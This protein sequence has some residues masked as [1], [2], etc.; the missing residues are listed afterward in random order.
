MAL[1]RRVSAG[2]LAF[3]LCAL[4]VVIV[5]NGRFWEVPPLP[6]VCLSRCVEGSRMSHPLP[7]CAPCRDTELPGRSL[8]RRY[9]RACRRSPRFGLRAS[10]CLAP[11]SASAGSRRGGRLSATISAEWALWWLRC[12]AQPLFAN[13][14]LRVQHPLFWGRRWLLPWLSGLRWADDRRRA[15]LPDGAAD[16]DAADDATHDADH[17]AACLAG[18]SPA[19][20][21][22]GYRT[23]ATPGCR[24]T[25]TSAAGGKPGGRHVGWC[26]RRQRR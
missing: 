2:V 5:R 6:I 22:A 18:G 12:A 26:A 3:G 13:T 15:A 4:L 20:R 21:H 1:P 9:C 19:P 17:A 24:T 11:F 8:Q 16:D 7:D 14:N 25:A 10:R 23:A